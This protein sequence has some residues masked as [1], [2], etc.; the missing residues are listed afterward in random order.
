MIGPGSDNN[1]SFQKASSVF[2][3]NQLILDWGKKLEGVEEECQ[4]DVEDI[5]EN[6][7]MMI[8]MMLMMAM[9]ME[10]MMVMVTR[11]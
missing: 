8:M 7:S 5:P 10:I 11:T 3:Y 4:G 1:A 9:I 2:I 6:L